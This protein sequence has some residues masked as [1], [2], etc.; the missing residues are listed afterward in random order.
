MQPGEAPALRPLDLPKHVVGSPAVRS[1][2]PEERAERREGAEIPDRRRLLHW[3][4]GAAAALLLL[5]LVLF[6]HRSVVQYHAGALSMDFAIFH[7]A[8]QQIAS[9]NLDPHSTLGDFP[10]WQ[11]HFELIMWPLALVGLVFPS[12]LTLLVLQDV[13]IVASEA[14]AVL[15]VLDVVRKDRR[16]RPSHVVPVVATLALLLTN[17]HISAVAVGDFHFQPFATALILAAA[18]DL[19]AGRTRRAWIWVLLSFLTG[20]VAGTYVAG[21]G[22]SALVARRDTRWTG[23]RLIAAGA[24]WVALVGYIGADRGSAIGGYQ[25]FVSSGTLPATGGTLLVLAAIV[26]HPSKPLAVLGGKLHVFGTELAGGG[27]LGLLHPWTFGVV[28]VVLLEGGLQQSLAF[29]NPFQNF[30]AIMFATAGSGMVLDWVGRRTAAGA[31]ARS[32][33]DL[34]LRGPVV[35]AA[36]LAIAVAVL[37]FRPAADPGSPQPAG[38]ARP[39]AAVDRAL[40]PDDQ[41]I[42][43]FGIVGRFAGRKDVRRF[44]TPDTVPVRAR[45]VVFVFSPTI[46]N[47]PF[48]QYQNEAAARVLALGAWPIVQTQDVKA[49]AWTPPDGTT[50]VALP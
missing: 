25:Q 2:R 6:I 30:P 37:A 11:S 1:A 42:A 45:R 49:Y 46:G 41:V 21:L 47:M 9:G 24:G 15:W 48:G 38:A 34:R 31:P 43:S 32:L 26:L 19:W 35:L 27:F 23:V 4:R 28:A 3:V 12:G 13:A 33:R 17:H 29:L 8:W 14:L 50:S 7:Q 10:Y 44:L 39:L 22:L 16:L 36:L 40:G 18:R 20:D 5:Q